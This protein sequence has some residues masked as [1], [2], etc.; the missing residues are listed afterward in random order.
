MRSVTLVKVSRV[1]IWKFH[2]KQDQYATWAK[3]YIKDAYNLT[4]TA[5]KENVTM[6]F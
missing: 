2:P 6:G 3:I 1:R 4:S 5:S